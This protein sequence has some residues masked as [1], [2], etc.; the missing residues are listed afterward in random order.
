MRSKRV[1]SG[2]LPLPEEDSG[3]HENHEED[4][5]IPPSPLTAEQRLLRKLDGRILPIT[6]LLYLF[7]CGSFG[8]V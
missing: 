2:V 1:D 4:P 6:C 3:Y 5:L 8:I 7:A